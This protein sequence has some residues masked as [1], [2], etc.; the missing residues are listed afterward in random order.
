MRSFR[1]PQRRAPMIG[2][3][4][5]P[6]L[7]E[8]IQ[9]PD[10]LPFDAHRSNVVAGHRPP[11]RTAVWSAL[12][13]GTKVPERRTYIASQR[14]ADGLVCQADGDLFESAAVGSK[15]LEAGGGPRR[16]RWARLARR[17]CPGQSRT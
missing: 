10:R 14:R 11:F 4:A 5:P 15:A 13:P 17:R 1:F 8:L 12:V 3:W 16:R 2:T 9:S 6:R 7:P